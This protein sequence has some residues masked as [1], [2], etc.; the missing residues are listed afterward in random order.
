[1]TALLTYLGGLRVTQGRLAGK[2]FECLPWQRRFLAK[3]FAPATQSAALSVGRGNGKTALLA[4]VACA[5]LDGPLAVARGEVVIVAASYQQ[6]RTAFDHVLAF[7]GD[8]L[9]DKRR[10]RTWDTAQQARIENRETG[11][12]VRVIG[13]DPKR[14]HGLAPVL[15]LADEGAQWPD[16]TGERMVAAL[17]TAAGKQP[18]SRF[19]ALGTRPAHADHW[20]SRM[21]AG[22]ADFAQT[23]AAAPDDPPMQRR[24]WAKA[25][26][27]LPAMPDL[28]KAI[29]REAR[30]AGRDPSL[31]PQFRSLRLNAG[32]SDT[33]I[34]MLVDAGL[35][36]L[37][38]GDAERS[39]PCVWG[40]DLGTSA[41]Q[42]A[43][44]SYWPSTGRLECV[45]AF[46]TDPGLAERGLR[47]GVGSLYLSCAERGELI[48]TPGRAVDLGVLIG[49]ALHR[50][51]APVALAFD[52]WREAE[53]RDALDKAR[54]PRAA[55][56][57]RGQGYRD[58]GEDVRQFRRACAEGKV[59]PAPSLLM[60]SAMS[61]ARTMSDAA[62]NSKL[63]KN[64]EGGRRAR[65]RDD[66]AAAT[67]L[68]VSLGAR[69]PV[70][71]ST[72]GFRM[73]E[74]G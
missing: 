43:I 31:L 19:I 22:G 66:S 8:K 39:G 45:A 12:S 42:S 25:N 44:A 18:H 11:A 7:M 35:W 3:A 61:E 29:E 26:P 6:G 34:Q 40:A 67:I 69:R 63:C 2:P 24:T 51:G 28:L 68:A 74:I 17:V 38:E 47:D 10:W 30:A 5:A 56:E 9:H 72:R 49:E 57:A 50:F 37:I 60:R 4:G 32:V 1:M 13:S 58:G 33:E 65:A 70:R 14:A 21:L 41:A 20:F 55:L 59:M 15:T 23:H 16:S 62:G 64:N 27:S 46:P 73:V 71:Q 54:V 53:F 48:Q 52:R 36:A